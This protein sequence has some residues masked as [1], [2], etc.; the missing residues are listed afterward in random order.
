MA[1]NKTPLQKAAAAQGRS[2]RSVAFDAG[3]EPSLV[4]AYANGKRPNRRNAERVAD[5][6]GVDVRTL[7]P[8]ADALRS[9]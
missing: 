5:A 9:Y 8:D 2:I 6:L 4:N 7:W 3:I 1:G